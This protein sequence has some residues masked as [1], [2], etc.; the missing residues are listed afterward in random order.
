VLLHHG[1]VRA[2]GPAD[3]V[4]TSDLLTEVYGIHVDVYTHP[5]TGRTCCEPLGRHAARVGVAVPA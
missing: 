5:L 2:T 1:V 3:E 4:L